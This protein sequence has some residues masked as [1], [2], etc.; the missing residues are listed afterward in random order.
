MHH[1]S[2]PDLASWLERI[3]DASHI[4]GRD[5]CYA[6]AAEAVAAL[7][8]GKTAAVVIPNAPRQLKIVGF[9]G[10]P[11]WTPPE[12]SDERGVIGQAFRQPRAVLVPDVREC[13]PYFEADP[14][15]QSELA[16][17][18]IDRSDHSVQGVINV[19][20]PELNHFTPEHET[21]LV[22]LGE[23]MVKRR[24]QLLR[25]EALKK[26]NRDL[27]TLLE[28]I[29]DEVMLIDRYYR[30]IW[31]NK[32]KRE[33]H[34]TLRAFL[35]TTGKR[36]PEAIFG[37][38]PLP[39]PNTEE[40]CFYLVESKKQRCRGCVCKMA[41][42]SGDPVQ[43]VLYYPEHLGMIVELSAAPLFSSDDKVIGCL[44]V[45]RNVAPRENVANLAGEL[46]TGFSEEQLLRS[47]PN[48]ICEKLGYDRARLYSVDL[49]DRMLRGV[50]YA[51]SHPH[52]SNQ[53]FLGRTVP[54][55]RELIN[56]LSE[57]KTAGLLFW[58]DR[59]A[60]QVSLGYGYWH[61]A[62]REE[63]VG[64]DLDRD[65]FL[66][67]RQLDQVACVPLRS[68]GARWVVFVDYRH[69]AK[70]FSY[71]DL[72][73][74]TM[75]AR[76]ASAALKALEDKK[77]LF[78]MAVL[79]QAVA[80]HVLAP[81]AAAGISGLELYPTLERTLRMLRE[82]LQ[83]GTTEDGNNF[84]ARFLAPLEA[85]LASPGGLPVK[86]EAQ[87][88]LH[89]LQSEL[90]KAGVQVD[91]KTLSELARVIKCDDDSIENWASMVR[92]V[93][94]TRLPEFAAS[95]GSLVTAFE[96]QRRAAKHAQTY[97]DAMRTAFGQE[98]AAFAVVDR[99]FDVTEMVKLAV[100]TVARR[101]LECNV[102]TTYCDDPLHVKAASGQLFLAFL[103]LLD[104]AL[105]AAKSAK[106]R[107][108]VELEV[109]RAGHKCRV[110]L[111]NNGGR[112]P[113][114]KLPKLFKEPLEPDGTGF[115][116]VLAVEWINL[117][118]GE[119]AHDY[120]EQRQMT[121]F[122]TL[123]PLATSPQKDEPPASEPTS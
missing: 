67:L 104:Y 22:R 16:V 19:E 43:G 5:G 24:E 49:E 85:G 21:V 6:R 110:T 94:N 34:R 57:G 81:I 32:V 98:D 91:S 79:G 116:L 86:G 117:S 17:P 20:S 54:I 8:G 23:V 107:P 83:K 33:N 50:A 42:D 89:R 119:I 120:D 38:E 122:T 9:W 80:R 65:G 96:V 112:I 13:E 63:I 44:E 101:G 30:P 78:Q 72:Q 29:P 11:A 97:V 92:S 69:S 47:I 70:A 113:D 99:V 53:Y 48:C 36:A 2:V 40:T 26:R 71:G 46:L 51:G 60:P 59:L 87:E 7:T 62:I 10:G 39:E 66:E 31:A 58:G 109:T 106:E 1:R 3:Y 123:L 37:A 108:R 90:N 76:L 56:V 25:L 14:D 27:F 95:M 74:L 18:A 115:G 45:A 61:V 105:V 75:F 88:A 64:T 77:L 73:A 68:D 102:L 55:P 4:A 118:G 111:R 93:C 35:E 121:V 84:L 103:A 114:S 28:E 52:V 82:Y 100:R 15:T 12:F 41:M